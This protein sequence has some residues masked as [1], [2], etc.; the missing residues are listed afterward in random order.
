MKSA[1]SSQEKFLSE[2]HSAPR[3]SV[4]G[5][6]AVP[7]CL[8]LLTA[9]IGPQKPVQIEQ[10]HRSPSAESAQGDSVQETSRQEVAAPIQPLPLPVPLPAE[11]SAEAQASRTSEAPVV[12][13]KPVYVVAQAESYRVTNAVTATKTDTPIMDTPMS[14]KVVPQQVMRDQQVVR[15]DQALKNV[16]GVISGAEGDMQFNVRGFDQFNFY[17]DGYPFQGQF[18]HAEDLTNIERVEVLKGPGYSL[19]AGRA[20]RHHQFR[21]QATA[22][23]AELFAPTAIRFVW[24]VSD[25]RRS[26]RPPY[27]G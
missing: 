6:L 12:E 10:D 3:A 1:E 21:D 11:A 19:R 16:S 23:S 13:V 18:F 9:C 27:C 24:L 8:V 22:G 17:R 14:V 25:Q 15:V 20:G 4:I 2:P 7:A 5:R 26:H